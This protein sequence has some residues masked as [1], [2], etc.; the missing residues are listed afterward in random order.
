MADMRKITE[1]NQQ[2]ANRMIETDPYWIDI[3]P[4]I[5]AVSGME[6]RMILHSGPPISYGHMVEFHKRCMRNAAL[7]E[8]WAKTDAEAD[9]ILSS[10]E[11]KLESALDHNTVGN[12]TGIITP[13][14][15]VM[16][17][18]DGDDIV[19][20]LPMEGKFGGGFGGAGQ[21]SPEIVENLKYLRN[22]VFPCVAEMLK[23]LDGIAI[24]P[25]LAQGM[26]MG[27]E[28]HTRQDA[29]GLFLLKE[30]TP[31]ILDMG[32][33]EKRMS[34]VM[35]YLAETPRVFYPMCM[36]FSRLVTLKNVGLADSTVVTAMGGNGVEFGIKI[37]AMGDQWFTAPA[38]KLSVAVPF[39]EYREEDALPWLG[40]SCTTECAGLG[41]M[42]AAASPIVANLQGRSNKEAI[43]QTR[44]M[45]RICAAKN[46]HFQIPAL[47]NNCLPVGIDICKVLETG[48]LPVLHGG[49]FH[50]DGSVIGNGISTIP[51]ECFEKAMEAFERCGH[52]T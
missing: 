39:R 52:D 11:I 21:F 31:K 37:A 7:L 44:A 48:I 24:R 25:I 17:T 12:G 34:I 2:A 50:R 6:D 51:M 43:E 22:E 18:R 23:K 30:L 5:E 41:G 14:M 16:V 13:S 27:D 45:E 36:S 29:A 8:G 42:A 47:D 4:A 1:A 19:A 9:E 33:E 3:R 49:N 26:Q 35:R 38:P 15:T 40:D 32:L 10:G 46:P 20:T 28:N